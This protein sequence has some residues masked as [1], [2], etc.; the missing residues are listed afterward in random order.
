MDDEPVR[1]GNRVSSRTSRCDRTLHA[2]AERHAREPTPLTSARLDIQLVLLNASKIIALWLGG[3]I[4]GPRMHG[5]R[6]A[7]GSRGSC[8]NPV[9]LSVLFAFKRDRVL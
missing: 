1:R 9:V 2:A 8:A 3:E 7:I 5:Q 4:S 6:A